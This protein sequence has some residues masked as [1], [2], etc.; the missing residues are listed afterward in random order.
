MEVTCPLSGDDGARYRHVQGL[1]A[2]VSSM[3]GANTGEFNQLVLKL[4]AKGHLWKSDQPL[5]S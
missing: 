5:N 3:A 2:T 4:N 1:T